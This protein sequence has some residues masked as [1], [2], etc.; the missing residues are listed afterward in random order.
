MDRGNAGVSGGV[1]LAGLRGLDGGRGSSTAAMA[2]G[3][4]GGGDPPALVATAAPMC[5]GADA[6]RS[7]A[8]PNPVGGVCG[9]TAAPPPPLDGAALVVLRLRGGVGVGAPFTN[10]YWPMRRLTADG[11]VLAETL[12]LPLRDGVTAAPGASGRAAAAAA[13]GVPMAAARS[14]C[15]GLALCVCACVCSGGS[16]RAPVAPPS[17]DIQLH[18]HPTAMQSEWAAW[19]ERG[20]A[21]VAAHTVAG[22]VRPHSKQPTRKQQQHIGNSNSAHARD[23]WSD[24]LQ[25][26]SSVGPTSVGLNRN[27]KNESHQSILL[28]HLHRSAADPRHYKPMDRLRVV[29]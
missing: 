20:A 13:A 17:C 26:H 3:G 18:P 14:V 28:L 22:S 5:G 25:I 15:S 11:V 12:P 21:A 9:S 23:S 19:A 1:G 24:A 7:M 4:G 2:G 29:Q 27:K 6:R 8:E 16:G 10:S